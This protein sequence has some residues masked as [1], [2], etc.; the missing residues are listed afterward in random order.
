MRRAEKLCYLPVQLEIWEIHSLYSDRFTCHSKI[1]TA[2]V[3]KQSMIVYTKIV[4]SYDKVVPML[5]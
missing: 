5:S 4:L 2:T 1:L 3:S